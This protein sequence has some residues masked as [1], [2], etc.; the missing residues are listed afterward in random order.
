MGSLYDRSGVMPSCNRNC[1]RR[2][3]VCNINYQ[4]LN[5]NMLYLVIHGFACP[6]VVL[7]SEIYTVTKNPPIFI[8]GCL[9]GIHKNILMLTFPESSTSRVARTLFDTSA[10]LTGRRIFRIIL[11]FFSF[12]GF[13]SCTSLSSLISFFNCSSKYN[14]YAP[15]IRFRSFLLFARAFT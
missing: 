9:H 4:R 6:A 3:F 12:K 2:C 8:T 14:A 13:S 15:A 7:V 1:Y 11:L 10:A 5:P